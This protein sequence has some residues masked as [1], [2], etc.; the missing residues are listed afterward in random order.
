MKRVFPTCFIAVALVLVAGCG[1]EERHA[2]EVPPV[3]KV[4]GVETARAAWEEVPVTFST[5]GIV[6]ATTGS[7]LTSRIV[8]NVSAILVGEGDRV[9][10]G[11]TLLKIESPDIEAKVEQAQG[12]LQ[13]AR[14]GLTHAEANF[15]RI[16]ALHGRG[17]ATPHEL[18]G[19]VM[20]LEAAK[21][22]LTQAEGAVGEARSFQG[23]SRIQAPFAGLVTRKMIDVGEQA[24][25]GRPLLAMEGTGG[26]QFETH[27]PESIF[28]SVKIGQTVAVTIDVLKG[29]AL[30]G[31]VAAM[32]AAADPVSHS[33]KVKID[34]ED[35]AGT[36]S[37]MYGKAEFVT[38]MR[39]VILVPAKAVF[40]R[41]QLTAVYVVDDG[42]RVHFRL[43]RRGKPFDDRLE[44]L[45]GLKG[46]EEVAISQL[47]LLDEG[48]EIV[49]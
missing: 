24:A 31:T 48:A 32:E 47:D 28:S 21:G 19:A 41:G 5:S 35:G 1:E 17:S 4:A 26:L 45:S 16:A 9:E 8:G 3:K 49:E 43:V 13:A 44:I 30:S 42:R 15:K 34:L 14:A 11:E 46:D 37:G 22:L 20:Q 36:L 2:R 23:Y 33:A 27:V 7:I 10:V 25:P 40:T 12:A 29:E 6:Q 38:G 18:D 39:D